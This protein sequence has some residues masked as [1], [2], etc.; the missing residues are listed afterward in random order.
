VSVC[1]AIKHLPLILIFSLQGCVGPSVLLRSATYVALAEDAT[2]YVRPRMALNGI[3]NCLRALLFHM[4]T[5][6]PG[7]SGED[8]R[9]GSGN[10]AMSDHRVRR[11]CAF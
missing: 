3:L 6:D 1:D 8:P 11:R 10:L 2:E 7:P 4:P 5:I 9:I